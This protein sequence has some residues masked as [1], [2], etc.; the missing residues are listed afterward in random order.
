MWNVEIIYGDSKISV[1][2][3]VKKDRTE[4]GLCLLNYRA[5]IV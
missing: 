3:S 4:G 2:S 1:N 5:L